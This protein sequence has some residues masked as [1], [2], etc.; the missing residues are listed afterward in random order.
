MQKKYFW[1]GHPIPT[2]QYHGELANND[3]T[4][5][6]RD[7]NK[8]AIEAGIHELR[9]KQRVDPER[10]ITDQCASK[11][12]QCITSTTN[13][14][15]TVALLQS[16]PLSDGKDASDYDDAAVGGNKEEEKIKMK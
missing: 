14:E 13:K 2:K 10:Y 1:F 9:E 16:S 5:E 15:Q 7:K 11:I 6:V 3:F 12:R 4:R 8:T